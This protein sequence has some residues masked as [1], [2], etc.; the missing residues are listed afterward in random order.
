MPNNHLEIVVDD[1]SGDLP[2]TFGLNYSK[3]P[4][5]CIFLE[6]VISIYLLDVFIDCVNLDTI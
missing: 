4:N 3:F 1:L 2:V 5:S 6:F